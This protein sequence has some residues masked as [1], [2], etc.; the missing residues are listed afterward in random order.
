[1][2]GLGETNSA[3]TLEVDVEPNA[4]LVSL[5][6][7]LAARHTAFEAWVDPRP[8]DML[9]SVLISVDGRLVARA[10]HDSTPLRDGAEVRMF[11]PYSGG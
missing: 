8:G 10:D 4:S 6:C 7:Q 2:L 3:F 11:P 5:F 9:Q 1:M